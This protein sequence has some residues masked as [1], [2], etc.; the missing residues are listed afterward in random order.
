MSKVTILRTKYYEDRIAQRI[1]D[2]EAKKRIE[3]GLRGV[4]DLDRTYHTD[5]LPSLGLGF[6]IKNG[7]LLPTIVEKHSD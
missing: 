6:Y 2:R 1:I 3:D 5:L 7:A 4:N